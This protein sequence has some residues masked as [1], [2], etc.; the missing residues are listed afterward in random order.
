VCFSPIFFITTKSPLVASSFGLRPFFPFLSRFRFHDMVQFFFSPFH[1]YLDLLPQPTKL[2]CKIS[3]PKHW[4]DILSF[5]RQ[6][7]SHSPRK[8]NSFI[9]FSH[10]VSAELDYKKP[11]FFSHLAMT[12][13]FL[14]NLLEVGLASLQKLFPPPGTYASRFSYLF[15]FIG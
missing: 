13:P 7:L 6:S 3:P 14:S 12:L 8:P 1:K 2:E 4:C 15:T 10:G 9:F 11:P 5:G